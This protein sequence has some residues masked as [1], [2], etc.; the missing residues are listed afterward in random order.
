[1][2]ASRHTHSLTHPQAKIV[3]ERSLVIAEDDLDRQRRER[4]HLAQKLLLVGAERE[5][6]QRDVERKKEVVAAMTAERARLMDEAQ[7]AVEALEAQV[8]W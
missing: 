2:T 8:R 7:A 6:L 5:D 4:D 3:A 1:M